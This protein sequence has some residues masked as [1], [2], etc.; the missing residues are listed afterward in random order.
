MARFDP[1]LDLDLTESLKNLACA[2][3]VE[4]T[5]LIGPEYA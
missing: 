5:L 1:F 2:K 4:D 3:E